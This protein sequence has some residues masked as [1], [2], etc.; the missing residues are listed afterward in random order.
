MVITV[1]KDVSTA[2][3]MTIGAIQMLVGYVTGY[4]IW[5]SEQT[6][7]KWFGLTIAICVFCQGSSLVGELI[8]L[9]IV[10]EACLGHITYS[11]MRGFF[12]NNAFWFISQSHYWI[13]AVQYLQTGIKYSYVSSDAHRW[14][15]AFLYFLLGPYTSYWVGS[16]FYYA[17]TYPVFKPGHN[18]TDPECTIAYEQWQSDKQEWGLK[19]QY[20]N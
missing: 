14:V 1:S 13:F 2:C 18:L 3:L 9:N 8:S 17:I 11:G 5:R 4:K 6:D 12:V 16:Q 10:R 7:G 15:T 20:K 19:Y